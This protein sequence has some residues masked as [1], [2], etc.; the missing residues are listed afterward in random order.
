MLYLLLVVIILVQ[1]VSYLYFYTHFSFLIH[2][3]AVP[4]DAN[5][6][7][8]HLKKNYNPEEHYFILQ[9]KTQN[10]SKTEHYEVYSPSS[11]TKENDSKS[12]ESLYPTLSLTDNGPEFVNPD[13]PQ[14]YNG[15]S[16]N[17]HSLSAPQGLHDWNIVGSPPV[18]RSPSSS[19]QKSFSN[20][21]YSPL[22]RIS[23]QC[24]RDPS[25]NLPPELQSLNL[26]S[27]SVSKDILFFL[28][29]I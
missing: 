27:L 16:S 15:I 10:L 22:S 18:P 3:L 17:S 9:H 26:A 11:S 21:C 1:F 4:L 7:F 28:I 25:E 19:N 24:V 2:L 8:G 14:K 20:L 6:Q 23:V 29:L 12:N 5:E 13:L